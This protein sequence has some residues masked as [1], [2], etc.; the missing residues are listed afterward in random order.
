MVAATLPELL[1]DAA[2]ARFAAAGVPAVAGL[3]TGLGCAAALGRSGADPA[4]LREIAASRCRAAP[5]GGVGWLPEHEAKELLRAAGV[6]VGEGRTV[7]GE[8]DAVAA[9]A[10]L[11]GSVAVKLAAPSV[12]HKTDAGALML[13]VRAEDDLRAA[14]RSLTALGLDGRR[15]VVERMAPPGAEL[16]V[17]A[18]G[19]PALDVVA[20]ARLAS[21][22]GELLLDAGLELIELN[23]VLVHERGAIAV[24]AVAASGAR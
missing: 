14:H 21:A 5:R 13:D 11:G 23:P 6:A 7:D 1:D 20:A 8:D 22:T 3:R 24:D 4:R 2:A 17:S 16:L 12:R 9:L 18:R 19:H 15:V 10:E